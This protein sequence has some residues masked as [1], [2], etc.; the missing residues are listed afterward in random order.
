MKM[1][2]KLGPRKTKV[3][4]ANATERKKNATTLKKKRTTRDSINWHAQNDGVAKDTYRKWNVNT[5]QNSNV[6]TTQSKEN[7]QQWAHKVNIKWT[8]GRKR[9]CLC[10]CVWAKDFDSPTWRDNSIRKNKKIR[11]NAYFDRNTEQKC[12]ICF[13]LTRSS[14]YIASCISDLD[15]STP[16]TRCAFNKL[17]H[18]SFRWDHF[19]HPA[20][21]LCVPETHC[22][23]DSNQKNKKRNVHR[24]KRWPFHNLMLTIQYE[25]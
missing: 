1:H 2:L 21:K 7:S 13:F 23:F 19:M 24:Q 3:N 6:R 15:F 11:S 17:K 5:K 14:A 10:V 8:R 4:G 22:A 18:I 16:I 20:N 25:W 9:M 12:S